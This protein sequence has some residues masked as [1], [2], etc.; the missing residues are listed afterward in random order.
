MAVFFILALFNN[1]TNNNPYNIVSK[2][3]EYNLT[4]KIKKDLEKVLK[5]LES[6][7]EEQYYRVEEKQ[8]K[9]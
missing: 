3:G 4:K 7:C 2:T 8:A 6:S 5:S 9:E 1:S